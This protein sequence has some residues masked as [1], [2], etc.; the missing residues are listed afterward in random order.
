MLT[1]SFG[2]E[3]VRMYNT[4]ENSKIKNDKGAVT[5]RFYR[6]LKTLKDHKRVLS[7]LCQQINILY[8]TNSFTATL[9]SSMSTE[10]IQS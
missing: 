9:N 10:E 7:T 6:S 1:L 4:Q 2:L 3:N 8:D 5:K